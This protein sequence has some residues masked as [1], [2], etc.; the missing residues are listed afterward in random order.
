MFVCPMLFCSRPIRCCPPPQCC[1]SPSAPPAQG[2][3]GASSLDVS[4]PL[5]TTALPAHCPLSCLPRAPSAHGLSGACP[6]LVLPPLH[7][8]TASFV[9]SHCPPACSRPLRCLSPPQC[10]PALLPPASHAYTT[11]PM[12][13]PSPW[14]R[15]QTPSQLP[16]KPN[17]AL[18][19]VTGRPC[20]GSAQ[21]T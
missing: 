5:P 20:D 16:L 19:C 14:L 10:C 18:V 6:S 1:P 9:P 3:P 8:P 21:A 12:A 13:L 17:S 4:P 15:S 7:A 2:L 11:V